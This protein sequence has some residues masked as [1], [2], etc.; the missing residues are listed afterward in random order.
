MPQV[1]IFGTALDALQHCFVQDYGS[2]PCFLQDACTSLFE[3][4]QTEGIFRKSGSVAHIK[5]LQAKLDKGEDCLS[6]ALPL[7]VAG[8][9]KQFFRELP[10]PILPQVEVCSGCQ[11]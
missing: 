10:E 9:L 5:A 2:V 6:S 4:M 7:D 8:L 1:K 11:Q 3:H